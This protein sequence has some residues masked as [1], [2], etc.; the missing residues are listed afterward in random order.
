MVWFCIKGSPFRAYVVCV[1]RVRLLGDIPGG[2]L[3]LSVH[4]P[5]RL[6]FDVAHAGPGKLIFSLIYH[7]DYSFSPVDFEFLISVRTFATTNY[8][9]QACISF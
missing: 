2:R 1:D 4:M 3:P 7:L 9:C 6:M 5:T 8:Y